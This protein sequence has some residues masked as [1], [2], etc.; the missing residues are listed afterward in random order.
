MPRLVLLCSVFVL[1][2]SFAQMKSVQL[3]G[4]VSYAERIDTVFSKPAFAAGEDILLRH[5]STYYYFGV[6]SEIIGSVN[7]LLMKEDTLT[8]IHVSGST[9]RIIYKKTAAGFQVTRPLLSAVEHPESWDFIGPSFWKRYLER[10]A[11]DKAVTTALD[12]VFRQ[13]GYK[14]ST[15]DMGSYLETEMLLSRQRWKGSRL[16]IQYR[17]SP[18]VQ[19]LSTSF[20]LYP[21]QPALSRQQESFGQIL[22]GGEPGAGIHIQFETG[23]WLL[24]D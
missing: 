8:V 2:T 24:L 14:S 12:S 18:A 7:F 1:N 23:K 4:F 19:M 16:L 15:T 6:H 11:T 10:E 22:S 20:A 17:K 3:D 5:D 21:P 9:G 13:Y